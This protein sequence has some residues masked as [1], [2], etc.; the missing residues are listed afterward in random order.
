VKEPIAITDTILTK[1]RQTGIRRGKKK[2]RKQK[3]NVAI[4]YPEGEEDRKALDGMWNKRRFQ[5]AHE[6]SSG[7]GGCQYAR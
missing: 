3:R 6:K 2:G 7:G 5:P 4:N 1:G